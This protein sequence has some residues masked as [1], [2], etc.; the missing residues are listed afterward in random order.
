MSKSSTAW[1]QCWY[2]HQAANFTGS[3]RD[4]YPAYLAPAGSVRFCRGP[5]RPRSMSGWPCRLLPTGPQLDH[6][7]NKN[8]F[9]QLEESFF[10]TLVGEKKNLREIFFFPFYSRILW[11]LGTELQEGSRPSGDS[12]EECNENNQR[13]RKWERLTWII[14]RLQKR[15]LEESTERYVKQSPMWWKY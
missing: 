13:S 2:T 15:E 14:H 11:D 9:E 6:P 4:H 3:V 12:P 7:V 10:M 5:H 8:D 1:H